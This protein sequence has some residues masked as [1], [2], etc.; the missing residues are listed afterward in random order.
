MKILNPIGITKNLTVSL[1]TFPRATTKYQF[2]V[3]TKATKLGL[4]ILN[5]H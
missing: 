5:Q 2:W 3:D 4:F 1:L